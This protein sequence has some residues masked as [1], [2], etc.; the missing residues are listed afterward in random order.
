MSHPG[1]RPKKVID[2]D[3]VEKLAHIQCTQQEIA[4]ILKCSV[5]TLQRN[6]KFCG[7][8]KKGMEEGRSSLRRLQ[9]KAADEGDH[10]MMIWLGKQYL[11]QKDK[12]EVDTPTEVRFSIKVEDDE[13]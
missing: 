8:Y 7:L 1:G 13:T 9:W 12:H 10:T 5:D 6:K 2:Y 11:G 3:L 4:A